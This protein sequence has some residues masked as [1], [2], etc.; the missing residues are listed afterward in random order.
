MPH[1]PKVNVTYLCSQPFRN[2]PRKDGKTYCKS[3]S[4]HIPDLRN[5]DA[6][7]VKKL[8]VRDGGESCGIFYR[9]QFSVNEKTQKG[10][11][12]FQ[13]VAAGTL[14][15][16]VGSAKLPAQTMS[17]SV[18]TEQTDSSNVSQPSFEAAAV[19]ENT[20]GDSAVAVSQNT[21]FPLK[22][23]RVNL[24]WAGRFHWYLNWRFPFLHIKRQFMGKFRF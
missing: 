22:Y 18:R 4:R 12:A 24:F 8:L 15:F 19:A 3:C 1:P 16:F 9:D 23:R 6:E 5:A 20:S 10:P 11:T 21:R 13:L 2:L 17:D 7:T 14:A